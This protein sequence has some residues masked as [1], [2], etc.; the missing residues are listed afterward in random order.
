[1]G[2]ERDN[3]DL[4]LAQRKEITELLKRYLPGTEVWAY[5]SR[6][7]FT[8]KP[9]S[10]LDM[11]A[12]TSQKIAAASLRE[13]FEE[14][15]L[16][17]RVDFFLWDEIPE[18]FRENIQ[19]ERVLLQAWKEEQ[20]VPSGWPRVLIAD[21]CELIVDCVNKTAPVV[22]QET[23]FRMIRTPN[24]KDGRVSLDGCRYVEEDVFRKWTGRAQ[25]ERDDVL[26]TREAPLG[27]VGIVKTDSKIFL[28]QRIMQYRADK[29]QLDPR[30]LLYSFL[31]HDLQHQFY[32]HEGSGSVVSHIRVGDC[33]KFELNL[34]PLPEQKAIA[35]ILGSLDD[36]IE[37][38][39]Q[40]NA[41]LE[42]MAQALFQSWFVNFDPVIDNALAAGNKIP[43]ELQA[44]AELRKALGEG[45]K[46][47]PEDVR[48][49][50]PAEFT[51]TKE[52]GWIPRGWESVTF[53][54][55]VTTKQGRYLAKNEME[56]KPDETH[57]YPVWGGNGIL[58]YSQKKAYDE[59][60]TLMTCR[61]SNCGLIKT[62]KSSAWVSNNSFACT[63][64]FGSE[65]F[66]YLYFLSENF[67]DCVS[68]SA[69]P[70]ITYTALKNKQMKFPLSLE[71]CK[72]FSDAV[73]V[74]RDKQFFNEKQNET[75]T[76]LRDT[77]LPKLISGELRVGDGERI[78]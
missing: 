34:P 65:Y 35:H 49:L 37:L 45:W 29:N 46:P 69:Q 56:E 73:Q 33:S 78:V 70:Q 26:L 4:T 5:G 55:L 27:Q 9:S 60:I 18:Q 28:G 42:G 11:V 48:K 61:G 20:G 57:K 52:M 32:L 7:K 50:F 67:S 15:R 12:F 6:V 23:P 68:G 19:A 53:E 41:T 43:E 59:P 39:R 66:L 76:K 36:K 75:L 16:P 74:Y 10:D 64:K 63:A 47:L 40:M 22:E 71:V 2:I 62:T 44:R 13:A 17:F 3:I 14:S 77:L 21:V 1:M 51:H 25:V 8:S 31:S 54:N 72:E 58:G 24:I 30:F 38:N